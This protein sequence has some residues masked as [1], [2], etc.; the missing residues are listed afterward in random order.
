[1]G[2]ISPSKWYYV[3]K[4]DKHGAFLSRRDEIL[5]KEPRPGFKRVAIVD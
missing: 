3:E 4:S 2:P 5:F 1:M